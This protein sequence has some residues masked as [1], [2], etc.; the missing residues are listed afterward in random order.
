[1]ELLVRYFDEKG[2]D[3]RKNIGKIEFHPK[4]T[5]TQPLKYLHRAYP[6]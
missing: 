6:D 3:R 2:I 5:I 4:H 1:M